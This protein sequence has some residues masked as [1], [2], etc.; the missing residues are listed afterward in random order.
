[1]ARARKQRTQQQG[2]LTEKKKAELEIQ[3]KT[4][5]TGSDDLQRPPEWLVDQTAKNE[6]KR[7]VKELSKIDLIGNLDLAMIGAYANAYSGYV[8]ASKNMKG[9]AMIVTRKGKGGAVMKGKNPLIGVQEDYARE[10][11][12]FGNMCGVS[13]DSRLKAAASKAEQIEEELEGKFGDI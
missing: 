11:R 1:M 6:F 12:T 9:K 8:R 10:M 7:V 2:D 13:I 3:E 5:K 4:I